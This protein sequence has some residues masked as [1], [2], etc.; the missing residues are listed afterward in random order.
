MCNR[1]SITRLNG[2]LTTDANGIVGPVHPKAMPVLLTA[3]EEYDV[4]LRA[5]WSGA[6][7]LQR[8]LPDVVMRIVASGPR[9]DRHDGMAEVEPPPRQLDLL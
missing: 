5:P 9:E 6:A 4:W 7:A 8:S 2:F 1:Y 3:A